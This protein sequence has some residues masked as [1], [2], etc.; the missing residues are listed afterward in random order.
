MGKDDPRY[1]L[2]AIVDVLLR[3][4]SRR[5]V[6]E[7][8]LAWAIWQAKA[9]GGG[10][11]MLEVTS[12]VRKA[13]AAEILPQ[14]YEL[15]ACGL[16]YGLERGTPDGKE[17]GVYALNQRLR[18]SAAA[19]EVADGLWADQRVLT[20]LD[21]A[22]DRWAPVRTDDAYRIGDY[23][24]ALA[25]AT[26]VRDITLTMTEFRTWLD[27]S[28]NRAGEVAK[29][30]ERTLVA[31][32]SGATRSRVITLTWEMSLREGLIGTSGYQRANRKMACHKREREQC[33]AWLKGPALR[34]AERI[35]ADRDAWIAELV[36]A[37]AGYGFVEFYRHAS[38]DQIVAF[39]GGEKIDAESRRWLLSEP[40][41]EVP[42]TPQ[43]D[44]QDKIARVKSKIAMMYRA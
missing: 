13:T 4:L 23:G 27:L 5:A 18:P 42:D 19:W 28:P 34:T 15:S 33:D 38:K 32:R 12:G 26:G 7:A 3:P 40:E 29:H 25:V 24:W 11:R 30:L 9:G 1:A 10:Q 44:P 22:L 31:H 35:L 21:P 36:A 41:P 20:E 37:G 14:P 39:V 2:A 43:E 17:V 8:R 16:I 6:Q